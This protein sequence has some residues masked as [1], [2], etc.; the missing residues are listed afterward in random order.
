MDFRTNVSLRSSGVLSWE[1]KMITSIC[2]VVMVLVFSLCVLII[3]AK[4]VEVLEAMK[5]IKSNQGDGK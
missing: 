3:T 5:P 1:A 4:T 2:S